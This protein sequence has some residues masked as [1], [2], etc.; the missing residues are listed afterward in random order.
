[1]C[2]CH[3]VSQILWLWERVVTTIIISIILK[4]FYAGRFFRNPARSTPCPTVLGKVCLFLARQPPVGQ[5]LLIYEVYRSHSIR[6]STVGR[7][8]MDEWSAR[9]RDL[10]LITHNTH[11]RQTYM[12]PVEFETTVAASERPQTYDL[13]RAATGTDTGY[14]GPVEQSLY[15]GTCLCV[16]MWGHSL[17]KKIYSERWCSLCSENNRTNVAMPSLRRFTQNQ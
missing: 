1:M 4:D 8:P 6:H 14:T 15:G 7:I 17:I 2:C 16:K 9:R 10:Y 5:G 3:L 13:D 11:N 12:L